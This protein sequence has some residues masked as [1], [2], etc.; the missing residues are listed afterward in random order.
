MYDNEIHIGKEIRRVLSEKGMTN[1]ALAAFIGTG[2][3]NIYTLFNKQTIDTGMLKKISEALNYDFFKFYQTAES[4]NSVSEDQAPYGNKSQGISF[5]F[6]LGDSANS[7]AA[8][9]FLERMEELLPEFLELER[10]K[11]HK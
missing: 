6:N 4:V 8:E 1:R 11:T 2:E 3:R 9:K 7:A 5:T 10:Q